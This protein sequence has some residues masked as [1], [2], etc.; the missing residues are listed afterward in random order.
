[1]VDVSRIIG[2]YKQ[3]LQDKEWARQKELAQ[4]KQRRLNNAEAVGLCIRTVVEPLFERVK[5]QVIENGFFCDIELVSK[6]DSKFGLSEK[7][8][9]I[10]IKLL[11]NAKPSVGCSTRYSSLQYA[12]GFEAQEMVRSE[13]LCDSGK[14]PQSFP[15]LALSRITSTL[16]EQDLD[17]F[18]R[19][20]FT[21]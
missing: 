12:G 5:Q 9:A 13:W 1:M 10:E 18:L 3:A 20:V 11:A 15:A 19:K 16:V 14:P 6:K 2:E 4:E 17:S 7:I 21:V 8:F